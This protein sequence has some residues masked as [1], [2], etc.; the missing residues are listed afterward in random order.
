MSLIINRS[1]HTSKV[2]EIGANTYL[3][4]CEQDFSKNPIELRFAGEKN[5]LSIGKF[6]SISD[7]FS[8][9][10][11][12]NH[13]MDNISTYPFF[14][15]TEET[16]NKNHI[17]EGANV[18]I[19][20]DVWIGTHVTVM[21]GV[22]IGDGACVGAYTIVTKNIGAYEIWAGNPARFIRSRFDA[23]EIA[24]LLR[25]KWW[26]WPDDLIKQ[27]I[28]VLQSGD[29]E[30]LTEFYNVFIREKEAA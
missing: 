8:V 25:L 17:A 23:I 6:C 2:A 7:C 13:N 12:G 27:A 22:T 29:I 11:G 10:C 21:Q 18:I 5:K 3:Y 19:G 30:G 28:P 24:A 4:T 20:S 16:D 14:L 15:F 26:N 9:L 1:Q